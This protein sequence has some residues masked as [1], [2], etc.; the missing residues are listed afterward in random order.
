MIQVYWGNRV[1]IKV[2]NHT[3]QPMKTA[4]FWFSSNLFSSL[5][6]NS[7]VFMT[8]AFIL[9]NLLCQK[10]RSKTKWRWFSCHTLMYTYQ[11]G[12]KAETIR[13][14][15]LKGFFHAQALSP[16]YWDTK[17]HDILLSVSHCL[18]AISDLQRRVFSKRWDLSVHGYIW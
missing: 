14:S 3:D 6:R 1:P 16:D 15:L 8:P 13:L 18:Q 17:R 10:A 9:R 12:T 2:L 5:N 11:M 4:K 7:V